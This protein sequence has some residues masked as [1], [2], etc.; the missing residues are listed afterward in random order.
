MALEFAHGT[1]RAFVDALHELER[2][3][4]TGPMASL[5][6]DD[7]AVQS[8]DG[9]DERTGPEGISELFTTYRK[10]FDQL[11]TTFTAVTEDDGGAALEWSTDATGVDGRDISY[12]GVTVI[13]LDGDTIT[14]FSTIYDSAALLQRP[15]IDGPDAGGANAGGDGGGADTRTAGH[16]G[17]DSGLLDES[18]RESSDGSTP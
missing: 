11:A 13:D 10:Q 15:A 17:A 4:D 1:T 12:R 9:H 2:S 8:I 7:A 14:R 16:T 6:T 3:G 5:F 18:D